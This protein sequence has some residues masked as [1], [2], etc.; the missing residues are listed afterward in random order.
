MKRLKTLIL[1]CSLV[2]WQPCQPPVSQLAQAQGTAETQAVSSEPLRIVIL[3]FRNISRVSE[4]EWLADSF[5]ESLTMGLLKVQALRVVERTQLQQLLREQQL[6]Q[7]LWAD[8]KTA[9]RLGKLLG[10]RVVV[11]GSFQRAGTQ[12]QANVRFVDVETGQIDHQRFAQTQGAFQDLFGLQERLATDLIQQLEVETRPGELAQ[13]S[14][15]LQATQSPEAQRYYLAGLEHLRLGEALRL[16][17]AIKDF[18]KALVEDDAYALAYAGLAEAYAREAQG[19]KA[20]VVQVPSIGMRTEADPLTLARQYAERALILSPDLPQALRAQAWIEKA[21]GNPQQAIQ[22]IQKAIRQA[23]RDSDSVTLYMG[24][25]M[26]SDLLSLSLPALRQELS[27]MGADLDDP[28]TQFTLAAFAFGL[29]ASKLK[30]QTDWIE[31][32]LEQAAAKLPEMPYIPLVQYGIAMR[33]GQTERAET[34]FQRTYALGKDSPD[35]LTSLALMR[36][37]EQRSQ[38]ALALVEA[39]EKIHPH[40]LMVRMTR[41]DVLADMGQIATSDAIYNALAQE[42]PDNAM[43]PFSRGIRLFE[44]DPAEARKYLHQALVN[45]EKQAAGLPRSMMI[46]FLGITEMLN[47]DWNAAREHFESLRTDPSYYGQAYEQL[48]TIHRIQKNPAEALAA[49]TAFLSI[50]P[51]QAADPEKQQQYRIYYLLEQLSREPNHVAALNDLGQISQLRERLDEARDYWLEALEL[52]PEEPVLHYNLGSLYLQQK[53]F[54]T[55]QQ[56]LLQAARLK[57]DYVRAW[58]NLGL[59][60]QAL[61]QINTAREAWQRVL[62]LEPQHPQAQALLAETAP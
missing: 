15:T 3:P 9:P 27:A 11:L 57:P 14:K 38:E 53:Q 10:A 25:R 5:A 62:L 13:L 59:A 30:P 21:A 12:L 36:L 4:D 58:F 19:E 55:A 1:A 47:Q 23:P 6:G 32:L 17:E 40:G 24:L 50:H 45:W 54:E 35:I 37:S 51:D 49:Y 26:E 43:I 60:S 7:S 56:H 28:W 39:A 61:G 20:L 41:A 29:E 46:Y 2:L 52:D 31:T 8:E 34:F 22:L 42:F 18:R 48:A 16:R 44:K 33:L